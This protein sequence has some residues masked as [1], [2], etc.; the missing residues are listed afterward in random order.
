MSDEVIEKVSSQLH[1]AVNQ[2]K[3]QGQ[4]GGVNSERSM[5]RYKHIV[6]GGR[7][8]VSMSGGMHWNAE[9]GPL[10]RS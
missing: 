6:T 2:L 5:V 10:N 8:T 4:I 1:R 9:G 3:Y 7:F